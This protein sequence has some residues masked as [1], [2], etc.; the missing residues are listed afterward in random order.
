MLHED[1]LNGGAVSQDTEHGH[2]AAVDRRQRSRQRQYDRNTDTGKLVNVRK[3][4]TCPLTTEPLH[5][6]GLS[7]VVVS[8]H[9]R[10]SA[11]HT[12]SDG[13][14]LDGDVEIRKRTEV[15]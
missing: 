5:E 11:T 1:D 3:R 15:S 12:L 2:N 13:K 7:G 14:R 10:P 9:G 6:G 4:T 8:K